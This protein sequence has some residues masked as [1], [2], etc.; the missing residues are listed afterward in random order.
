[1]NLCL[2]IIS[3]VAVFIVGFAIRCWREFR[4]DPIPT[5]KLDD[6]KPYDPYA[7]YGDDA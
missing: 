2:L 1:M 3:F 4:S 5:R 7:D 6:G